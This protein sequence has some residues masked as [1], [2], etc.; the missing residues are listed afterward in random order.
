MILSSDVSPRLPR[1][2]SVGQTVGRYELLAAIASGGM[3][4]VYA[5]RV[6]DGHFERIVALKVIHASLTQEPQFVDMFLDEAR[7]AATVQHPAVCQVL[8]FGH[9]DEIYFLAM[10]HLTGWPIA[11]VLDHLATQPLPPRWPAICARIASE[12]AAG[13]H[14]AH[15]ATDARG[16]PLE[17]V[18]RD[19]SPSNLFLTTT[20]RVKVLDFGIAKAAGRLHT[21]KTGALKGKLAYMPP[22]L[23]R[24]AGDRANSRVDIWALGVV[25]WEMLA[26][27]R[28]FQRP[29]ELAT[30]QAI[31]GEEITPPS[32]V[33]PSCPPELD[34]IIMPALERDPKRRIH[35]A[36]EMHLALEEF[37]AADAVRHGV[38]DMLEFAATLPPATS[39][40]ELLSDSTLPG[41]PR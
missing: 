23:L 37:L 24:E 32:V 5:A 27:R 26:R 20:G 2:L 40:R 16:E 17:V 3:G 19:V 18:H 33:Q 36:H 15:T 12:T 13:L 1:K 7:I 34:A 41:R 6:R 22:E 21:T 38:L 10:E 31:L 8:D 25:L 9:D 39:L 35:S 4:T 28:L 11:A 29:G 14:A 30:I